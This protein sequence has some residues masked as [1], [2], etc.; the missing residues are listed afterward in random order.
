MLA[1][2]DGLPDSQSSSIDAER[3][4]FEPS[5]PVRAHSL[6]RR[7]RSTTLAPLQFGERKYRPILDPFQSYNVFRGASPGGMV[8]ISEPSVMK[9]ASMRPSH[10]PSI[11]PL[12][13]SPPKA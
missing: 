12:D 3:E 8:A 4:G 9:P 1:S 6:S 2:G 13:P 5:V 10:G 7:A 11:N